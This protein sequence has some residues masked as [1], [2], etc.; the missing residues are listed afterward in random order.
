MLSCVPTSGSSTY[1]TSPIS[2]CN[3]GSSVNMDASCSLV[4]FRAVPLHCYPCIMCG[5]TPLQIAVSERVVQ[6][7]MLGTGE[8]NVRPARV[9]ACRGRGTSR[10]QL[11]AA[12]MNGMP[13][14]GLERHLREV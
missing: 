14:G 12:K 9:L 11:R 13:E 1:T 5:T 10:G 2:D 8:C 7:T 3:S 4:G 6:A